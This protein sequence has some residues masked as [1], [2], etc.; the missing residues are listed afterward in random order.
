MEESS[1]AL[2]NVRSFGTE[3]RRR[4]G[5]QVPPQNEI[6][7]IIIFKAEDIADLTVL[8]QAPPVQPYTD[9]AIISASAPAANPYGYGAPPAAPAVPP[10]DPWATPSATAAA[11]AQPYNTALYG[12]SPWAP[13][14]APQAPA[15]YQPKPAAAAA[16]A[17]AAPTNTR[18]VVPDVA[19]TLSVTPQQQSARAE[20]QAAA[21]QQ[22]QQQQPQAQPKP[23]T[24]A[25][26]A[27]GGRG[28]GFQGRAP[29]GGLSAGGRD[30]GRFTGRNSGVPQGP[31]GQPRLPTTGP[32]PPMPV[33][34]EDFD[35]TAA[36]E[37]FNKEEISKEV[38]I[39]TREQV[40][41]KD[42]FFDC[43]SCEALERSNM[44]DQRGDWRQ[45]LSE[46]KRLDMETFGGL[47]GVRHHS[48]GRG[49]GGGRG[50]MGGRGGPPGRGLGR[51]EG[52][53]YA[54]GRTSMPP[55]NR[56]RGGRRASLVS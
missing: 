54:S 11:A 12:S 51:G 28:A 40:Y 41:Q 1:I 34:K 8:S 4:D 50:G 52:R 43:L 39:S 23:S 20:Q 53:G 3:G 13:S 14:A 47:G 2:Q 29:R 42:D 17:A 6:Y 38:E 21:Q 48:F 15:P 7:E 33:P 37:K 36:L 24:W 55:Q 18:P 26:A 49:R 27:G 35:F 16:T 31:P 45:K 9:P 22:Q 10:V 30:G 46:Q 5:P 44:G 19:P 25:Q 32:P 56:G